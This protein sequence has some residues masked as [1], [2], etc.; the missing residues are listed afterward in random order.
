MI[1]NA[2]LSVIN[3]IY[4]DLQCHQHSEQF[5]HQKKFIKALKERD[6]V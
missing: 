5:R 4:C 3:W 6:T 2:A 1:L